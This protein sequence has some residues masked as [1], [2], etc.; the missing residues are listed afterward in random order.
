MNSSKN[1]AWPVTS[2]NRNDFDAFEDWYRSNEK[3]IVG[4]VIYIW[5]AG[6]RGTEFELFS[7]LFIL[8]NIVF[9]DNNEEKWGGYINDRLIVSPAEAIDV[10]KK[11]NGIILI[12][13]E[14]DKEIKKQLQLYGLAENV[15]YFSAGNRLY[16]KYIYEFQRE[17]NKKYLVM[18]DCEFSTISIND[19]D[20]RNLGDILKSKV[21]ENNIKVLAMHG[22]GLRSQYSIARALLDGGEV[23]VTFAI[24]IN[25][26]T[27]NGY[28]HLLPRSQHEE[29]LNSIYD[30]APSKELCDYL[31]E[32]HKRR[33]NIKVEFSVNR[34]T[35]NNFAKAKNYFMFNYMYKLDM[36]NEGIIYLKKLIE[37]MVKN[38]VKIVP[39][40]PPVNFELARKIF[41]EEFDQRYQENVNKINELVCSYG[42]KLLDLSYELDSL[43][44]AEVDTPDETANERGRYL[45][46]DKIIER[47]ETLV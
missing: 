25:F 1:Y 32:V 8:K 6:I 27:L 13:T 41:G 22:M 45:I 9:V 18:G 47:M 17:Y 16:E 43:M 31:K 21:G 35:K 3:A 37:I 42:L 19:K 46:S 10:V 4:R 34:N 20:K 40:I 2:I 14:E 30:I 15:D 12:S 23:P 5:G 26:D 11:K 33:E 29:L 7:R 39:F 28:Q 44:F 24:M 36:K 38:N